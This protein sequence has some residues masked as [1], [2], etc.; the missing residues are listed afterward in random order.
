MN[1]AAIVPIGYLDR[2]GYQHTYRECIGSICAGADHVYLV[3]STRDEYHTSRVIIDNAN[4]SVISDERTWFARTPDGAEWFNAYEVM[5][6]VNIGTGQ[7]WQDGYDQAVCLMCNW[8]VP[9]Q[10]WE[11]LR[12]P[13]PGW[14]W[15]Y[16]REHLAGAMLGANKRLPFVVRT[17]APVRFTVDA[18]EY[19]GQ[20]VPWE[21]GDWRERNAEAV[22]DLQYELTPED[23]EAK[24][25]FIRNYHDIKPKN[26]EH[27]RLSDYIAHHRNRMRQRTLT[28]DAPPLALDCSGF[29]SRQILE[30]L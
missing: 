17:D 28:N 16:K 5:E 8:Y 15:L 26:P 2:H 24:L 7:A 9:P 21:D 19:R 6:N 1:L 13:V 12:C 30:A 25:A 4:L 3:A 29:V 20:L 22:V 23:L 18:I 11:A 10:A 27:A 14:G